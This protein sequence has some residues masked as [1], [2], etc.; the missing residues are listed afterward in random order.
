MTKTKSHNNKHGVKMDKLKKKSKF[1]VFLV[2][3]V[4]LRK[5]SFK[6]IKL[7]LLDYAKMIS[8]VAMYY[9][10]TSQR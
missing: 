4:Q 10:I 7:N 2:E 6:L 3:W 1:S 5:P 8:G 9:V